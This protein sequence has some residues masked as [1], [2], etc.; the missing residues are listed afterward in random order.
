MPLNIPALAAR[1]AALA[2][3]LTSSAAISAT[4]RIGPTEVYDIA[5]DTRTTTWA[6]ETELEGHLYAVQ[7]GEQDG[8]SDEDLNAILQGRAKKLLVFGADLPGEPPLDS[9]VEA[10]G[11]EWQVKGVDY[12]PTRSVYILQLRR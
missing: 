7:I 11:H 10:D 6:S 12:D 1:G 4:V 8:A 2:Q 5:T 9:Q 3:R